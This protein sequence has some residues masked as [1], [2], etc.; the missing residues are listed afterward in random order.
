MS[1]RNMHKKQLK[2]QK[3]Q[4]NNDDNN[5]ENIFPIIKK[6]KEYVPNEQMQF[7][8]HEYT[9]N[10]E[11]LFIDKK[12]IMTVLQNNTW[13]EIKRHI[14]T[15]INDNKTNECFICSAQ[16]IQKRV[17]CPKCAFYWCIDCYINIF[18]TNK[19][20]I[21]CP[22]CR[23]TYGNEGT[24]NMIELGVQEILH[25]CGLSNNDISSSNNNNHVILP[26]KNNNERIV[27]NLI[28]QQLQ[29]IDS[30]HCMICGDTENDGE[31][32]N[33]NTNE[34]IKN[35]CNFCYNIQINMP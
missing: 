8:K 19:G 9:E 10:L 25:N 4:K 1:F 18:R 7:R 11:I 30:I 23:F 28:N 31:I 24:E 6:I 33:I 16:E 27:R 22:F 17:S 13:D 20:I 29:H 26:P 14:D 12:A 35:F 3:K 15:K 32:L 34:G 2:K 21:K 5:I